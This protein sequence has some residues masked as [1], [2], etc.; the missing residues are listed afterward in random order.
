MA[1]FGSRTLAGILAAALAPTKDAIDF[2]AL[3]LK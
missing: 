1:G 2:L 3:G